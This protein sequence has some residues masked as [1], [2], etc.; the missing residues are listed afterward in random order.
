MGRIHGKIRWIAVSLLE[1][2][3]TSLDL[4]LNSWTLLSWMLFVEASHF[5]HQQI[6]GEHQPHL[7]CDL[8]P[9]VVLGL[10]VQV[11]VLFVR[12]SWKLW[13]WI[14]EIFCQ[15]DLTSAEKKRIS[16]VQQT[17]L[18]VIICWDKGPFK[19]PVH[20]CCHNWSFCVVV[21]PNKQ[22]NY[23][24]WLLKYNLIQ[25]AIEQSHAVL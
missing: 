21:Y 22:Y 3:Y 7:L 8:K 6:T 4:A 15:V 25:F 18:Q 11:F 23:V 24:I 9:H 5:L 17:C 20:S 13:L 16:V 14:D 12:Q 10:I 19:W 1:R 2:K